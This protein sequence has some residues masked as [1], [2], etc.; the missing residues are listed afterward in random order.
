MFLGQGAHGCSSVGEQG[1]G[2]GDGQAVNVLAVV[3]AA[4]VLSNFISRN[5][6]TS[7]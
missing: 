4:S 3:S 5:V 1:G 2:A 6:N 7:D